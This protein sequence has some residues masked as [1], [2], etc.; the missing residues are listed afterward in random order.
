MTPKKMNLALKVLIG[1]LIAI[2][3][4]GLYFAN[5]KLTRLATE[6]A[7][8]KTD[9]EVTN[10]RIKDY[11]LTEAKVNQ[12]SYVKD[13]AA[14]IVPQN[15]DQSAIVAELAEFARRSNLQTGA[16]TFDETAQTTTAPVTSTAKAVKPP[17]GVGIV[18]VIFTVGDSAKYEDVLAFLRYIEANRR[19]M[20]VTQITLTPNGDN[21]N[22]LDN[23]ILSLNL[24]VKKPVEQGTKK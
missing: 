20:Q 2:T 21:G 14:Q 7:K 3:V 16:I 23:V 24:F 17:A 6:T 18:P 22:L 13:L 19:K 15:E 1:V 9:I 4:A 5:Q 8:L 11:E 10:Q 12:L